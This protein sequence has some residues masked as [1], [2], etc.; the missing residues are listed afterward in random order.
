MKCPE[1]P[2]NDWTCPYCR[3]GLCTMPLEDGADPAEECD[4]FLDPSEWA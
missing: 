2:A 1:C 3:E 4:E